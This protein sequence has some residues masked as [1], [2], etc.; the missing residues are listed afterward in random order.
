MAALGYRLGAEERCDS[1]G[2][3]PHRTL[4]L[5]W[6]FI[7]M[8]SIGER[9]LSIVWWGVLLGALTMGVFSNE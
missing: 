1:S 5:G 3:F 9:A 7:T 4:P 2:S 6:F 8:G